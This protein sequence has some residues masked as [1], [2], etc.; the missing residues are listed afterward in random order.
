MHFS[1]TNN[2][3]VGA[4]Q[5]DFPKGA[6]LNTKMYGLDYDTIKLGK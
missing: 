1:S 4:A 2:S 3:S 5:A 6:S